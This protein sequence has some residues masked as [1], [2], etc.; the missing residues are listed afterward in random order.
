VET[1][2]YRCFQVMK[3]EDARL[4]EEWAAQWRDL[5]EFEFVP[6]RR[7]K[8]AVESLGPEL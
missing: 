7:S 6:V 3:C 8:E 5:V 1:N 2:F 4:L